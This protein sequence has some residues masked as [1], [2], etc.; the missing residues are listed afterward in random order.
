M[1]MVVESEHILEM[2]LVFKLISNPVM[3][4]MYIMALISY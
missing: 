1:E 3:I 4:K 2:I